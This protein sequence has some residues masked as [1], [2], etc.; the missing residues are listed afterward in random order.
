MYFSV[1]IPPATIDKK[2]Q[3]D[4]QNVIAVGSVPKFAYP[5]VRFAAFV[6][7][8]VLRLDRTEKPIMADVYTLFD[9]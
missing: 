9:K 7:E 4:W 5:N 6:S 8:N 1:R 3:T 2:S